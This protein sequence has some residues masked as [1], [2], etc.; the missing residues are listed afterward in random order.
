M[1]DDEVIAGSGR[2]AGIWRRYILVAVFGA[3]MT[4]V[5]RPRNSFSSLACIGLTPY[6]TQ[7]ALSQFWSPLPRWPTEPTGK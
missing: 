3:E 2:G 7:A 5:S 4:H 1:C 6:W